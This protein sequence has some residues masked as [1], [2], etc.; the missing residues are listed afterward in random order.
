M[1]IL[2]IIAPRFI[3]IGLPTCLLLS[4]TITVTATCLIIYRISVVSR[5]SGLNSRK[6]DHVIELMAES[7]ALYALPL[8]IVSILWVVCISGD[9]CSLNSTTHSAFIIWEGIL[10]PMTVCKSSCCTMSCSDSHNPG[11]IRGLRQRWSL[12]ALHREAQGVGPLGLILN[13][14]YGFV[15]LPMN[16]YKHRPVDTNLIIR[17]K[18]MFVSRK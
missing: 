17:A 1:G 3:D 10:I 4:V 7:G 9:G 11:T 16:K 8:L 6:F 13:Q 2:M 5:K 18:L 12:C 14:P 15:S